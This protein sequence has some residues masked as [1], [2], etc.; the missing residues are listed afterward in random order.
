MRVDTMSMSVTLDLRTIEVIST[1]AISRW[2]EIKVPGARTLYEFFTLVCHECQ[3]LTAL[4]NNKPDL[5]YV[6]QMV[7]LSNFAFCTAKGRHS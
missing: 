6:T 7:V 4:L 2:R 3:C 1:P 5:Q